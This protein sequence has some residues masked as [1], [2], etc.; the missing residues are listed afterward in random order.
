MA[1]DVPAGERLEPG[2]PRKLFDTGIPV[3]ATLSG[4]RPDYFYAVAANGERFMLNQPLAAP[5]APNGE[6]AP[7]PTIHV[8]ANWANG[9]PER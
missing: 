5:T 9:L 1:L 7:A 4:A 8:I 3:E 2:V 6:A